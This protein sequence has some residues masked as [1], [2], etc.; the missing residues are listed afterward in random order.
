MAKY[1][2]KLMFVKQIPKAFSHL[3]YFIIC[4]I[5]RSTSPYGLPE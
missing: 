5:A 2:A 3:P 1:W 4:Q